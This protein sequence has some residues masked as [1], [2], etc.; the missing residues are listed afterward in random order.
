[1]LFRNRAFSFVYVFAVLVH[2][3]ALPPSLTLLIL[4]LL[5][6]IAGASLIHLWSIFGLSAT[7]LE[8]GFS[9]LLR[10]VPHI[11]KVAVVVVFAIND[12]LN[13]I[14]ARKIYKNCLLPFALHSSSRQRLLQQNPVFPFTLYADSTNFY[15]FSVQCANTL[16]MD[17][18]PTFIRS[19]I[20]TR[21]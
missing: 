14:C 20:L 19:S 7:H 5:L 16:T 4:P 13:Y 17:Q 3:I 10:P 6:P 2:S 18:R 9:Y 1:M 8:L 11:Y 21:T 15:D 12:H